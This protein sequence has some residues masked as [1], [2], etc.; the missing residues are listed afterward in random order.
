[1]SIR[2]SHSKFTYAPVQRT[3]TWM[4]TLRFN[5]VIPTLKLFFFGETGVSRWVLFCDYV[6]RW[7]FQLNFHLRI[8]N[9][10]EH[11]LKHWDLNFWYLKHDTEIL[12]V[13]QFLQFFV[14][15]GI[16]T[17]LLRQIG[18]GS[19]L[20]WLYRCVPGLLSSTFKN[21]IWF[22]S[23]GRNVKDVKHKMIEFHSPDDW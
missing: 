4:F 12:L 18:P 2:L 16:N 15:N 17:S 21:K 23:R 7:I 6:N 19:V 5:Q 20:S 14:R 9:T 13:F 1:M 3:H 11:L 10:P 22:K 8:F